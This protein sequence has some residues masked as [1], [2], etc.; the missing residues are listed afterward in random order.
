MRAALLVCVLVASAAALDWTDPVAFYDDTFDFRGPASCIGQGD[1]LWVAYTVSRYTAMADKYQVRMKWTARGGV[2][3]DP[4]PVTEWDSAYTHSPPGL[5]CDAHGRLWVSWYRGVYPVAGC[6][7]P[8]SSAVWTAMRDSAGLHEPIR[9]YQGLADGPQT[10]TLDKQGELYLGFE[11]Q[12]SFTD[13]VY[14]SALCTRL[15]G[16]TWTTPKTISHGTGNPIH[17]DMLLPKLVPRHDEGVWSVNEMRVVGVN[18]SFGLLKS[19]RSDTVRM[20]R[21]FEGWHHAVTLDSSDHLWV[22]FF[23]MGGNRL[24]TAVELVNG[25]PVDTELVYDLGG[26]DLYACA[27]SY[28]IVWLL[29]TRFGSSDPVVSH[30]YGLGWSAPEQAGVAQGNAVGICPHRPHMGIY[31]L[32]RG[33]D[34]AYYSTVGA[35]MPGV[36]GRGQPVACSRRLTAS[37]V[38]GVL[39]LLATPTTLRHSLLDI[40]GRKVMDLQ[41]GRNDVCHVAPGV[42]FVRGEGPRGQ[43]VKGSSVRKVI[44]QH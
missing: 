43:G 7:D 25:V 17:T 37:V 28:R 19:L 38:R 20:H 10:F 14:S 8:E 3:S 36:A 29:W 33:T 41:S 2:W 42:Y 34:D 21:T 1:T 24:L 39:Y 44:V 16:D 6:D 13:F 30:N 32:Y 22:A 4:I 23:R 18:E 31:V 35:P 9:A 26:S 5:G 12:T 15:S 27:D 40:S 11:T